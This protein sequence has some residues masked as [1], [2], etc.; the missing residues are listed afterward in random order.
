MGVGKKYFGTRFGVSC[1]CFLALVFLPVKFS[2][3]QN[4]PSPGPTV[5]YYVLIVNADDTAAIYVNSTK[6]AETRWGKGEGGKDIGNRPGETGLVDIT[7]Y[8]QPGDNAFRFTVNN[9]ACCQAS[10]RF[11]IYRNNEVI[12]DANYA[13]EESTLGVV[14]DITRNI[15]INLSSP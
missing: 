3:G 7:S 15:N 10:G 2:Q 11:I 12:H 9:D 14:F 6:A 13:R 4:A 1:L 5:R 8:L